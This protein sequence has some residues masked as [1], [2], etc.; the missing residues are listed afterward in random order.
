MKI[1]IVGLGLIGGSAAK[2]Y[3]SEPENGYTVLAYNRSG[4]V[5]ESAK[6]A[7]IIDGCLTDE[8]ISECDFIILA[9]YPAAAISFLESKAELIGK[10]SV[11]IDFCGN[12]K[13]ICDAC[14]KI[15]EDHGFTFVGGHPMAGIQYSGLQYAKADL[16][17]NASMIIVPPSCEDA[18]IIE[19]VKE[20]LSPLGFGS[21]NITTPEFHDAE[22]AFTSQLA[23]IVSNAYVKSPSA[24]THKGFSAGSYRD[25]TRVAWLNEN[26]WTEL[27]MENRENILKELSIIIDSLS[28]YK[29]A[30]EKNDAERLKELLKDGRECK[31]RA[32]GK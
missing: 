27:F 25:L 15:A 7:G 12:K 10:D 22:I 3:K 20:Y 21:Y 2:A 19:R 23:H 14:F 1:G 11:V 5:I 31:E 8:N 13:I 6:E 30:I 9:L 24:Q 16:F 17:K 32:D 28:E 4:A 18:V 26:M 29:N